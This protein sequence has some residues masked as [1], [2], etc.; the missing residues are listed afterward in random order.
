VSFRLSNPFPLTNSCN[1]ACLNV[2]FLL[3]AL[4]LYLLFSLLRYGAGNLRIG[5]L[6]IT[7]QLESE[8][9]NS[10]EWRKRSWSEF[11]AFL[12]R[13]SADK[14]GRSIFYGCPLASSCSPVKDSFVLLSHSMSPMIHGLFCHFC[15][16]LRLL[17]MERPWSRAVDLWLRQRPRND[18]GET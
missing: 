15:A 17:S 4:A 18:V 11:A 6:P 16:L 3:S 10:N 9:L 13:A 14:V 8:A 5:E 7:L 1:F 2:R 12:I